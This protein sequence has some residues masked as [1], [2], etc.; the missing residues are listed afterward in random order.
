L[1][2]IWVVAQLELRHGARFSDGSLSSISK[3]NVVDRS[4]E[5]SYHA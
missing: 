1:K 5:G 4:S 2:A 3:N